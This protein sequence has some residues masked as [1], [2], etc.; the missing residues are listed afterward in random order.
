MKSGD[1][2]ETE[3]S[4]E[5]SLCTLQTPSA[6]IE[7]RMVALRHVQE[8]VKSSVSIDS[9]TRERINQAVLEN[10][11]EIVLVEDRTSDLMKRQLMRTECFLILATLLESPVLFRDTQRVIENVV[12][13]ASTQPITAYPT[14]PVS[15]TLITAGSADDPSLSSAKVS[16]SSRAG[17]TRQNNA[18]DDSV[19]AVSNVSST[20][21]KRLSKR[22]TKAYLSKSVGDLNLIRPM[23][24]DKVGSAAS[25][26]RSSLHK[27]M[28]P[29]PSV[30]YGADAE[31]DYVVPGTDPS[32]WIEHDR[33]LG[34]QKTRMW[35]PMA[36]EK[37]GKLI[38]SVR[39]GP[40]RLLMS[41]K[42]V[43]EYLQMKSM[44]S[45]VGDLVTPFKGDLNDY[46]KQASIPALPSGGFSKRVDGAVNSSLYDQAVK[47]AVQVW[48]PL[49]GTHLPAWASNG[50]KWT[51]VH[52][53]TGDKKK[54]IRAGTAAA[55][56]AFAETD[57][58]N[59]SVSLTNTVSTPDIS[60]LGQPSG[61]GSVSQ[62]SK[63]T[64]K[65]KLLETSEDTVERKIVFTKGV[66]RRLLRKELRCSK[67]TT[68]TLKE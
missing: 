38:P 19:S 26:L 60:T 48:T 31:L 59:S 9:F 32:N 33:M 64:L 41:D 42:V 40:D 12:R 44:L 62:S 47:Q 37:G 11:L 43:E 10:V 20:F 61:V 63:K 18:S 3:L 53:S 21:N 36:L 54:S 51:D 34:Y 35:F 50:K 66:L 22:D 65:Q 29:R 67:Q 27:R 30:F 25:R 56:E 4:L 52:T 49:I 8:Y 16:V 6:H 24:E 2:Y 1:P 57:D 5:T 23:F 58:D 39:P 17:E 14:S 55:A 28:K 13:A 46:S 45:Y 68:D 15:R 7:R